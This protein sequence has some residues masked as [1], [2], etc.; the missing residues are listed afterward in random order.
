MKHV[1]P[2]PGPGPILNRRKNLPESPQGFPVY[3]APLIAM[4]AGF[5][6]HDVDL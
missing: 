5:R 1:A 3:F 2:A 6:R 4:D